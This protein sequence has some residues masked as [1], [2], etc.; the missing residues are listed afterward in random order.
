MTFTSIEPDTYTFLSLLPEH[1]RCLV[2]PTRKLDELVGLAVGNG[3]T[4]SHLAK[5][6]SLG[7]ETSV[8]IGGV[9]INRLKHYAGSRTSP[10]KPA[11][12]TT[13]AT[14]K[15]GDCNPQRWIE[16]DDGTLLRRCDCAK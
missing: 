11:A 12:F 16:H 6:C 1:V 4:L 7:H 13:W 3:W 9:V 5:E 10:R 15:C 14:P 2:S 8:S